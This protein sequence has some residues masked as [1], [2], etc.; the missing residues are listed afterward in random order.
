MND[1]DKKDFNKINNWSNDKELELLKNTVYKIALKYYERIFNFYD[2][3]YIT[4]TYLNDTSTFS[5]RNNDSEFDK[6]NNLTLLSIGDFEFYYHNSTT[7][8]PV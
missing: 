3:E 4:G 2:R 6:S 1:H 5:Y 7:I 8:L